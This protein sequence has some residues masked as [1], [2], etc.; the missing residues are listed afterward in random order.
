M[1]NVPHKRFY[2]EGLSSYISWQFLPSP[3]KGLCFKMTSVNC[4]IFVPELSMCL[5]VKA[6]GMLANQLSRKTVNK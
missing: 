6:S 2:R 3:L 1:F 5:G 4:L